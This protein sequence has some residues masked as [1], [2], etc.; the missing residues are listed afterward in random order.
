MKTIFKYATA[1]ALTGALALAAVSPSEARGGRNTAAAVGFAAGAL[2]GAAAANAANSGYYYGPGPYYYDPGPA[3]YG[4]GPYAYE[5]VYVE[6]GPV[7]YAP[8]PV[9]RS[10]GCWVPTDDNRGVGYW[11]SCATPGA[12][13]VK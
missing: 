1:A 12:R 10:R 13:L 7:Y 5:R 8:Q 4:P 9:Y 6:P 11:G 2:V 3:Y